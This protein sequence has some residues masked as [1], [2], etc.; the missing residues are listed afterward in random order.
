MKKAANTYGIRNQGMFI[1]W[2][3]FFVCLKNENMLNCGNGG[4]GGALG[5]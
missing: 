2:Q 1:M 4:N 5:S 3:I